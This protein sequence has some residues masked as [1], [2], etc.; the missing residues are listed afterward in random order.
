[1]ELEGLE[2]HKK[3]AEG[4]R[5]MAQRFPER[6]TV[7]DATLPVT[8]IYGIVVEHVKGLM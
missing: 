2:F 6:I 4:Y 1:M 8:E 5:E 7:I 3:V